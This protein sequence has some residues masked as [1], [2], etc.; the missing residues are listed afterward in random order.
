MGLDPQTVNRDD[1]HKENGE[2]TTQIPLGLLTLTKE[3]RKRHNQSR[4]REDIRHMDPIAFPIASYH[5]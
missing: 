4:K 1:Y 5:S 2:I 3:T